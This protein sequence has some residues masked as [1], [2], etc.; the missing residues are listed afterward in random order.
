MQGY[1]SACAASASAASASETTANTYKNAA[2]AAKNA[3]EIARN[4]AQT[5]QT[6]AN[7]SK[8]EAVE[9]NSGAQTAKTAAES[10]KNEAR[11]KALMAEGYAFGTQNGVPVGPESEYYHNNAKYWADKAKEAASGEDAMSKMDYDS[12]LSVLNAGGIAPFVAANGG[13]I[14]VFKV[15]GVVQS[16]VDK[17]VDITVPTTA[18]EVGARPDNWV[19]S[20]SDVG[21]RPNTWTPSASDVGALPDATVSVAKGGTGAVDAANARTNLGLGGASTYG[22]KDNTAKASLSTGTGLTTERAV[23]YNSDSRLNRSTN[24]NAADTNYGTYMARGEALF[25]TDTNPTVNGC[26]AWTY[27]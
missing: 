2:E 16:I 11:S 5:A 22:V 15:N 7:S 14:D 24:V 10:A 18:A 17:A 6:A 27:G 1:V 9:A 23:K 25:N 13:K 4:A 21:A 8:N 3:A 26:I 19:P 20:A 12:D